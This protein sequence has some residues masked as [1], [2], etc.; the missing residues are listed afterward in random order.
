MVDEEKNLLEA[1]IFPIISLL[2]GI[3]LL[4]IFAAI[5]FTFAIV[6]FIRSRI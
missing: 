4:I 3:C 2:S 1:A 5:E 6:L